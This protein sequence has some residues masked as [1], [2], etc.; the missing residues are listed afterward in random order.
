[1]IIELVADAPGELVDQGDGVDED[2]GPVFRQQPGD[3]VEQVDIGADLRFRI[4]PLH[5]DDDA[6]A[7]RQHGT[8]HLA[9]GGS[10]DRLGVDLQEEALDRQPE[11]LFDHAERNFGRERRH[12]VLQLAQLDQDVLRHYV[13]PCREQLPELDEGR[14]EFLEH[15]A[16]MLA[17]RLDLAGLHLADVRQQLAGRMPLEEVSEAVAR[18]RLDDVAQP[19]D[20]PDG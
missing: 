13:R 12:L 15:L 17:A 2:V 8:V 1:M 10:S 19:I 5:L 4:R 3:L 16:H 7:V 18:G 11:L 9:D 14:P 6:V 20:V